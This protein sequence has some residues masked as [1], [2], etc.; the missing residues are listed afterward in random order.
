MARDPQQSASTTSKATDRD[1]KSRIDPKVMK[2]TRSYI[3]DLYEKFNGDFAQDFS[4]VQKRNLRSLLMV[5]F[6]LVDL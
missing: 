3:D 6:T 2:G 1:K 5:D 4:E